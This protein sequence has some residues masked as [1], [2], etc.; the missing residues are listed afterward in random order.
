MY[1]RAHVHKQQWSHP[2]TVIENGK[3]LAAEFEALRKKYKPV[4]ESNQ[5]AT[6]DVFVDVEE[7]DSSLFHH[8]METHPHADHVLVQED[9]A[10][11]SQLLVDI[12][13]HS[14][15]F[16]HC[17]KIFTLRPLNYIINPRMVQMPYPL[18]S[19][20]NMYTAFQ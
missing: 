5:G 13:S 15:I 14:D 8:L 4:D 12:D 6:R 3:R 1:T 18:R 19:H 10:K 7:L 16:L 9:Q 11:I 17:L 20:Y 2:Q